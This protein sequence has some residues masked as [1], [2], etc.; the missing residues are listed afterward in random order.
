MEADIGFDI[1]V[2]HAASDTPEKAVFKQL[3]PT[4]ASLPALWQQW[5]WSWIRFSMDGTH[6]QRPT[7]PDHI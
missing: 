1:D 6:G 7:S 5:T 4:R 3:S 2:T